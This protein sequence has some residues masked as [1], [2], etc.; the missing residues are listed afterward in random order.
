LTGGDRAGGWG[1]LDFDLSPWESAAAHA[2]YK[3]CRSCRFMSDA[4]TAY[5]VLALTEP[6]Q[7]S[8]RVAAAQK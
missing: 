4:A 3:P 8:P 1:W 6:S 2:Q 5:A 7:A